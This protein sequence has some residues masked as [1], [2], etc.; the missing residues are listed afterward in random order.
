[1][2]VEPGP[3]PEE[4]G[5]LV[6]GNGRAAGLDK[7]VVLGSLAADGLESARKGRRVRRADH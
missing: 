3:S 6:D 2:L 5:R 7:T 4:R 1:M